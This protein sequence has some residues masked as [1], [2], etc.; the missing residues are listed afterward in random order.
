MRIEGVAAHPISAKGVMVNPVLVAT[1]L[2]AKFD[3]TQ[4]P[5]HTEGREGYIWV[6]GIRGNQSTATIDI[7]IRD[8]DQAGFQRRKDEVRA[9]VEQVAKEHPR[10]KISVEIEDVYGNIAD[11]VTDQNRAGIDLM[12]DA[13]AEIGVEPIEEPMRGG[14]DGSWLS[15][16]GLLT[17]NLFTG[18]H[19][20]HSRYEF[21]PLNAF[22]RA[23]AMVNS[24]IELVAKRA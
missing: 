21:L 11:A 17:P 20:F 5:E 4:T 12:R 18:G 9:V 10:A 2:I 13:L 8:F 19:N 15:A 23:Y 6:D 3:R 22:E 16:Q 1:D 24:L 14:T 7:N